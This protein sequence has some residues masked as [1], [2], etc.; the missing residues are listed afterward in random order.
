MK[1]IILKRN[2]F[3]KV[4]FGEI[5]ALLFDTEFKAREAVIEGNGKRQRF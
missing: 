5:S 4:L 2:R 3:C 1:I